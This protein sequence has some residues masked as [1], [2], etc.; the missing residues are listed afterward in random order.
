MKF[1]VQVSEYDGENGAF[2]PRWR[3]DE[4]LE[5]RSA[6]EVASCDDGDALLADGGGK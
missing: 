3:E 4:Q 6:E 1:Q 2:D 5:R